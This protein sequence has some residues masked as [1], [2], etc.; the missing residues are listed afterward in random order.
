MII[1]IVSEK[2]LK[3]S[4]YYNKDCWDYPLEE[5]DFL[6]ENEKDNNIEVYALTEKNRI[7]ETTCTINDIKKL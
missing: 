2:E 6:R 4:N 3:N 5:L 1:I 7:Y